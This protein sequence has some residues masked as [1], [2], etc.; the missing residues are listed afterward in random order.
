L[1]ELRPWRELPSVIS[2]AGGGREGHRQA[3]C[4]LRRH[5]QIVAA[6]RLPPA[7]SCRDALERA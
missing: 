7:G 3:A 6:V 4:A 1:G 2:G 5:L